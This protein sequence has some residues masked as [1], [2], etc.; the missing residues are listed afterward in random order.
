MPKPNPRSEKSIAKDL[1]LVLSSRLTLESKK[2]FINSLLWTWTERFGKY[3]G[4]RCSVSAYRHYRRH[5]GKGLRHD[6][7]IPRKL[8]VEYFLTQKS[9]LTPRKVLR[10]LRKYCE[11]IV[12]TKKED[13][14]LSKAGLRQRMPKG[15]DWDHPHARYKAAKIKLAKGKRCG[16]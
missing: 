6:H 15:W 11:G 4:C 12:L 5:K 2:S 3:K 13:A 1:V 9:S 16:F 10:F 7:S 8:I 14:I